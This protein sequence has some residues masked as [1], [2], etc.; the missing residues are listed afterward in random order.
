ML[1]EQNRPIVE[2]TL[3]A[4]GDHIGEI[5][6]RFYAHMFGAHPE[7]LDGTFNRGNQARGEQQQALAGSVAAFASALVTTPQQ[8]PEKL[9]SRIAHKHASLGIRPDQYQV[10]H[11]NLM[12]AIV[13][14]LGDAVTPE[15]AAAWDEV[16]WLMANALINQERGLYSARGVRPE[17]VWR[18]WRVERKIRETDDVLTFVVTRIDDRL[19]KTSLP[20]QYVTVRLP[21]PDGLH[22][23]RQYS[24]TRADDGEHRQF[25]VK[26][27]HGGGQPDG[28]VSTLLH[29]AVGVGDVLTLSLP[30]GDVVLDDAG[31]PVVFASAGMGIAPMAGMLSHL[32]AAGSGLPITVLHADLDESSFALRRQVVSDVLALRD[33]SLHLWYEKQSHSNEPVA[34]VHQG[35]MDLD[36]VDLPDDANY[37]LCGPLP[38]MQAVRSVLVA[39]GVAP[40]DIQYEVF[41]PDLWQADLD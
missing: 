11:D 4:V 21:M 10:V 14:V 40:R 1:S 36:Q 19:V 16:Y 5:A 25:T 18:P 29:D 6:Q 39:R 24:L 30:Y 37:Y 15:V 41:G 17:T 13:D 34:G 28:E 26:R 9:L 38:F 20:G 35:L 7:L 33:A 3:P 23:P 12:W 27:V 2:A 31:R 22:Q 8:L 32:V